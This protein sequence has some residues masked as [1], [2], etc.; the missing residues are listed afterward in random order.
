VNQ[1]REQHWRR[2]FMSRAGMHDQEAW[3]NI[4]PSEVIVLQPPRRTI[5]TIKDF[6]RWERACENTL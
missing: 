2:E 4:R 3:M 1:A 6:L 5:H